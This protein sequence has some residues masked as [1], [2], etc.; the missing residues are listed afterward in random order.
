MFHMTNASHLFRTESQLNKT[1]GFFRV[2]NKRWKGKKRGQR[3]EYLYLPL[4]EGKMV[5]AFDHRAASIKVNLDN[6]NRPAQPVSATLEQHQDPDWLPDPQYWVRETEI[7]LPQGLEWFVAF[8]DVTA[9]TNVRT[10]IA[11]IVPRLPFGNTLPILIPE[12][13]EKINDYRG[14]IWLLAACFNSVMFD[15]VARQKVQGQHLNWFIVEQ[16]PVIQLFAYN[17]TT[18][19]SK[20]ATEIIRET[21]LELTYTAHDM[22]PFAR[23]LGHVDESGKVKPPFSWNEDRRLRLRA[24]LD[25]VF[26]NLY[27]V[28]DEKDIKYI[29]ST[30]PT[31]KREEEKKYNKQYR[32]RDLCLA[33]MKTL[34]AGMPDEEPVVELNSQQVMTSD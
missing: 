17:N 9:T 23:D 4:Y 24:K 13:D 7:T 34:A 10:M 20:T 18:F 6:M 5:Q 8:K 29:Y 3:T 15:F 22:E 32:S 28:T 26:F 12:T 25:A 31:M 11:A 21:I 33:Y 27:S 19:G 30:F 14:N 16:L 1:E 2:D